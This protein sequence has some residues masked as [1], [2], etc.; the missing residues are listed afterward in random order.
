[1]NKP[2]AYVQDAHG[3]SNH[4]MKN[5]SCKPA[6]RRTLSLADFRKSRLRLLALDR[7]TK[8]PVALANAFDPDQ[9]RGEGG[10]F[11]ADLSDAMSAAHAASATAHEKG[12]AES[13][14]RAAKLHR[15]A[16]KRALAEN[17]PGHAATHEGIAKGHDAMAACCEDDPVLANASAEA[18]D[19]DGWAL[20]APF[21]NH[22]KTRI[23]RE[24]GLVKEQKFIQVLD[25]E[26]ADAMV[27]KENSMFGKLK[28]A[29][30]GIPVFKGHGDLREHDPKALANDQKIKLGV[31]DQVRKSERGIEAHFALDND[32][33][34]AVAAGWKLPSAL[35]LVQPIGNEGGAILARPFKLLSVALT[36][37]PNIPGVESLAN[38]RIAALEAALPVEQTLTKEPEMK[39]ITGWLMAQGVALANTENPT[40][41][42]VLEAIQKLHTSKAADVQALGNEKS[43]LSGK[44][45]AL[46]NEKASEKKRADEAAT[47][48]AN[49]QTAR[50]A[51]HKNAATFAVDLAIQRGKLTVADRETKITALEN[52][53]TFDADVKALVEGKAVIKTEAA[54]GKQ[55]AAL[56]N[57]AQQTA[58]EYQEAFKT[59]LVKAGQ[60]PIK[61]HNNIMR[62][63]QYSGLAAKLVPATH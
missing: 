29:F 13:H 31:V 5:N 6:Y 34:D 32:G 22:A 35:W 20:I 51:E 60:D 3:Q 59:E 62:L 1:M 11:S 28:R 47:A 41:T 15:V 43:T 30:I 63:P 46:E 8:K 23:Y 49:E 21:G 54:S 55:Q 36:Q 2:L 58:A 48:L 40:E 4:T 18:I 33:A 27:G 17:K 42:Q 38:A 12:D 19:D 16:A 50:K 10:N 14:T 56:S 9:T 7:Q 25:N 44:I 52:S 45:A 61:A 24:N 53:A 39:L 26:S 57:E 37:F